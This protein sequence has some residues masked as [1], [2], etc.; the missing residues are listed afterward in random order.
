[1]GMKNFPKMFLSLVLLLGAR[2][3]FGMDSHSAESSPLYN[4]ELF[5]IVQRIRGDIVDEARDEARS[6]DTYV[7]SGKEA[8]DGPDVNARQ[9]KKFFRFAR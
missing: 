2:I 9:T 6:I 8:W 1:M 4:Y 7:G 3:T 5:K